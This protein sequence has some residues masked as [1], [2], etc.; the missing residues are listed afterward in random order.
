MVVQ[1]ISRRRRSIAT[2]A[3]S[4]ARPASRRRAAARRGIHV[5][6]YLTELPRREVLRE[7]FHQ[8]IAAARARLEQRAADGANRGVTD[9]DEIVRMASAQRQ[10]GVSTTTFGVGADFDEKLLRRMAEAGGGNFYFIETAAQIPDF[11]AGEV[12]DMLEV[13]V[14]EAALVVEAGVD[15]VVESLN[16]FPSRREGGAWRIEL[17]AL[18]SGQVLDP[19]LVLTRRARRPAA[20]TRPSPR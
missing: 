8:A 9:H 1:E 12:G 14:P 2:T 11:L 17:G 10:L 5:A 20:K 18:L 13:T 19:L 15:V 4:L 6:E 16:G 3:P 7:R